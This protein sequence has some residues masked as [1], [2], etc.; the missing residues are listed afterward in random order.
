[1]HRQLAE[2]VLCERD[3]AGSVGPAGGRVQQLV[4]RENQRTGK[5]EM[6]QGFPQP[7]L[8]EGGR[9]PPSL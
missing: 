4:D 9:L 3:L 1:L 8:D 7:P 5:K 6:E 2:I